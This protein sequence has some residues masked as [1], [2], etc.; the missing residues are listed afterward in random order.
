MSDK[1][2]YYEVLGVSRTA[3]ADEIKSAYR[4]LAMKYHPD[5]NPG[6]KEAEEKFKEA[7]EAY[8]VLHD[9]DKRSRYDQFGHQAFANGGGGGGFGAGGMNM[10]DIFSMFGDV[11]GGRGG[12]FSGFE[13]MFGGGRAR[14]VNP[15]APRHGEDMTFKLEID[16]DEAIFG[17]QRTL[18]LKLPAECTECNGTGAA[19]GSGRKTCRTCGGRGVVIGGG[20]F[21][22]VRQTCHACGGEGSTIEKPCKKCHGSGQITKPTEIELKIPA[23]VFHG[24][25]LRLA[26]KGAG[27]L[28]GGQPGDLYVL[29]SVKPSDIFSRDG[30]D[31]F[32]DIPVSPVVAA[33]GGT[34]S[35]PTPEGEAQLKIPAGTPNGKVFRLRGKGV[36]SLRG[37][38][39]GDL[40]A[41]I[42]IETPANLDRRQKELLEE[43]AKTSSSGTFPA[44][45]TFANR[46]RVFFSHREKL[47]K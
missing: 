47:K 43:F 22:Q 33:L 8:D 42:I 45:Q 29:L 39:P 38:S 13:D 12:G 15:N 5:R 35:V 46:V 10:E 44:A 2:D 11:F 6:D 31:L 21:F 3:T 37:G 25:R 14:T 17:S 36:A 32:V 20:G 1:R 26:G 7:A 41:R 27:G 28:R 18:Q 4:K 9:A 34:I 30:Q 24:S 40:D 19:A 16:F 23:G